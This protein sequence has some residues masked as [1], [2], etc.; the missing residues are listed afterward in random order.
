MKALKRTGGNQSG[1]TLIELMIGV[2]IIGLVAALAVPNFQVAYQKNELKA[3]SRAVENA[4]AKARSNAISQ[5]QTYGVHINQEAQTYTLF[6]NDVDPDLSVLDHGDSVL[7]VDTLPKVFNYV[8]A[9][10]DNNVVLF[11]PNGSAQV[12]GYGG[13]YMAAESGNMM[14]SFSLQV[15]PATGRVDTYSNF[16]VW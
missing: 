15:T 1:F 4:L 16:Y 10:L 12:D 11:L 9:D 8:Y 13:I 6:R 14:G 7:S 5:K 3:G 2:V